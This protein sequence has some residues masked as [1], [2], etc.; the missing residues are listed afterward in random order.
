MPLDEYNAT[1]ATTV[2]ASELYDGGGT[3]NSLQTAATET[4][5]AGLS[6]MPTNISLVDGCNS[7]RVW[8]MNTT[9]A[10][11]GT[12]CVGQFDS[13][14]TLIGLTETTIGGTDQLFDTDQFSWGL[15]TGTD[16]AAKAPIAVSFQRHAATASLRMWVSASDGG[17]WYAR[18]QLLGSNQ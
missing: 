5:L 2:S 7:I 13:A 9:A 6:T 12:L 14:G 8:P 15:T 1:V 4:A 16:K 17:T 18:Y 10:Q 11:D 3:A